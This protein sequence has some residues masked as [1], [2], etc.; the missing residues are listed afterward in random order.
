MGHIALHRM[1]PAQSHASK[2]SQA[3]FQNSLASS[4]RVQHLPRNVPSLSSIPHSKPSKQWGSKTHLSHT[5]PPPTFG[6]ILL[7]LAADLGSGKTVAHSPRFTEGK[8]ASMAG[9]TARPCSQGTTSLLPT[10]GAEAG[11][12]S[13]LSQKPH[14]FPTD[15]RV[16][17]PSGSTPAPGPWTQ[18]VP[19]THLGGS[20]GL[21]QTLPPPGLSR[22]S[23]D[24][25]DQGTETHQAPH[26]RPSQDGGL[27][28]HKAHVHSTPASCQNP[29]KQ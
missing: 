10:P 18:S 9:C 6:G 28:R 21:L 26:S 14:G 22:G 2:E 29:H 4:R 13:S 11:P 12:T 19:I 25:K 20:P 8:E 17:R 1:Q 3:L 16:P 27:T 23:S 15:Q 24:R 7:S 5:H